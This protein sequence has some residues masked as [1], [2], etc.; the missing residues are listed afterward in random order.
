[1]FSNTQSRLDRG[2]HLRVTAV[3]VAVGVNEDSLPFT[4]PVAGGKRPV[5][6]GG[7]RD[8]LPATPGTSGWG[9][10]FPFSEAQSR[11]ELPRSRLK[12]GGP[13]IQLAAVV[14]FCG[15]R[16]IKTWPR[17]GILVRRK[18]LELMGSPA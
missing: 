5:G 14:A 10:N 18:K 12:S 2:S 13:Q 11:N 4:S 1:M 7:K 9:R 3:P 15:V 8:I 6:S 16:I 17:N